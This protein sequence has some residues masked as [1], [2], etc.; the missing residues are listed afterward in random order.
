MEE[1]KIEDIN[2]KIKDSDL[3]ILLDRLKSI[4]YN[5]SNK[6][7][8]ENQTYRNSLRFVFTDLMNDTIKELKIQKFLIYLL[9]SVIT[10]L[11]NAYNKINKIESRFMFRGG[12]I[13]TMYKDKF[14]K[15][16]S[17][18]EKKFIEENFSKF[19][20]FSD[21]DF[22]IYINN[23]KNTTAKERISYRND[24]QFIIHYP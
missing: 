14:Q 8:K 18:E 12:N 7:P 11:L 23:E 22:T 6:L 20:G 3:P 2:F 21:I 15:G 24:I 1:I 16:L 9:H 10:P 17:E 19:F 5:L 13:L 4:I